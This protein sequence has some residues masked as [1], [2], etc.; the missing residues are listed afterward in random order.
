MA[1][2]LTSQGTENGVASGC[3]LDSDFSSFDLVF[4]IDYD[5]IVISPDPTLQED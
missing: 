2:T 1:F 4:L 5:L 3:L